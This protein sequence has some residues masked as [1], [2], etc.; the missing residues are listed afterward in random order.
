MY[1]VK[2]PKH[3]L[4]DFYDGLLEGRHNNEKNDYL[5]SRLIHIK[6]LLIEA[7]KKYIGY[8]KKLYDL[9]ESHIIDLPVGV[10]LDNAMKSYVDTNEMDKVYTEFFVG[11]PEVEKVGRVVYDSII[12]SADYNICPYCS[13]R[14]VMT[15]DHYLPKSKFALFAVTPLN[16]LPSCS[17]CNKVKLNKFDPNQED[18]LIHPYFEDLSTENWLKCDVVEKKWPITFKYGVRDD[19]KNLILKARLEAQFSTL[20]LNLLYAD[21]ATREF[22]HR[23]TSIIKEYKSNPSK[24]AFY[25]FDDN[26]TSYGDINQNSWQTKMFEALMNSTWFSKEALPCLEDNYNEHKRKEEYEKAQNKLLSQ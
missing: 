5:R 18:M 17:D 6:P 12:S 7:E 19:I 24:N 2:A 14:K 4:D 9:E 15:L 25:F 13:D 16:L 20:K 10:Q 23:I 22:M 11:S 21:N 26:K 8:R 3:R 1:L